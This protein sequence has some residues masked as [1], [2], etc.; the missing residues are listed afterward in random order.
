MLTELRT[1]I[2]AYLGTDTLTRMEQTM[3]DWLTVLNGL[4]NQTTEASAAQRASFLNLHN[5]INSLGGQISDLQQQLADAL[6]NSG[7]VTPQMQALA[8]QIST[9][10]TDMKAAADTADDGFEPVTEPSE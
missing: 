4:V 5:G 10:L 7:T 2:R 9:S 3:S 6:A 1:R 8:D